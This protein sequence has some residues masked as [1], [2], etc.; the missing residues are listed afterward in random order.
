MEEVW[1]SH[2]TVVAEA[3][4]RRIT[5]RNGR[6]AE[7][8]A[9]AV[10]ERLE[11]VGGESPVTPER[12]VVSAD[13]S[14]IHLTTGEWREVKSVAVGEFNRQESWSTRAEAVKATAISYFTRSYEARNFER[15]ALAELHQ[16]GL[17]K[18][19]T[20]VAVND[21]AAWI[22][23]FLDYHCP[24]AVRILDFAHALSYV[25]DAG[26]AIWGEGS[27]Q[28]PPWLARC[29]HPFKHKPPQHTLAEL[30]LLRPQ[31]KSDQ[32]TAMLDRACFYLLFPRRPTAA[33]TSGDEQS[34]GGQS[35]PRHPAKN[36]PWRR[37]LWP[38]KEAWRWN[39]SRQQK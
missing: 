6:A 13:G 15:Y 28:F 8:V 29:A 24:K 34:A 2:Q 39:P 16:R 27:D 7:G 23:S 33:K 25:S 12:L 10:V 5:Y 3:T 21:G 1:Y 9:R 18:A 35:Q 32:Q 22:Q 36:H 26:K 37:G 11:Q 4:C 17:A 20:V 19:G 31:A 14:F 38:T 30:S